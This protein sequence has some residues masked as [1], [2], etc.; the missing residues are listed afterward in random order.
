MTTQEVVYGD[1][2][3]EAI[4]WLT[5]EL[6][7]RLPSELVGCTV[8]VELPSTWKAKTSPPH[9]QVVLDGTPSAV[10]PIIARQTIRLVSWTRTH[11]LSKQLC[12]IAQGCLLVHTGN[13]V[14]SNVE[15]LTGVQPARDPN[16]DAPIA[17]A[18][19]RM[20]VRAEPAS[21]GS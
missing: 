10:H 6:P 14:V 20:T 12:A 18:T 16:H 1:G 9:V 5:A 8:G 15:F 7:E 19:S 11:T 4:D 13:E 21:V 17:S 3:A 2:E